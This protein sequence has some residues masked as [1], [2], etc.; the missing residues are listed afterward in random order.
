MQSQAESEN[1]EP[2]FFYTTKSAPAPIDPLQ[3]L[4]IKS[5]EEVPV[6][7]NFYILAEG[8]KHIVSIVNEPEINDWFLKASVESERS[9]FLHTSKSWLPEFDPQ[10]KKN[11]IYL[12]IEESGKEHK[13][14]LHNAD[15]ANLERL[16][17]AVE[18]HLR[19]EWVEIKIDKH[20]GDIALVNF[21]NPLDL[22]I[23][24]PEKSESDLKE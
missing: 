3:K 17:E 12:V 10:E 1:N 22:S 19:G 15:P 13:Y 16:Q 11:E 6:K 21:Y 2:T 14:A 18:R 23:L 24:E 20:T 5:D 7:Q 4:I 8:K 9:F